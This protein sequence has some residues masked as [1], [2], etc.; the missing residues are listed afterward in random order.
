MPECPSC[1]QPLT[2]GEDGCPACDETALLDLPLEDPVLGEYRLLHAIGEGACGQVYLA[3]QTTM[4]RRAALKLLHPELTR[5]PKMLAR[6]KREAGALSAISHPHIVTVY[7]FGVRDDGT[8]YLAME[9]LEGDPLRRVLRRDGPLPLDRALDLAEQIADGL[10]AA[11]DA[12]VLHRDLKPEN[13][14]VTRGGE[15]ADYVKVLDFGIAQLLSPGSDEDEA[16]TL[17]TTRGIVGT[18]YYISPEQARGLP[19]DGRSDVYALGVL[20]YEL[21]TGRYPYASLHESGKRDPMAVLLAH[22]NEAPTPLASPPAREPVPADVERLVLRALEKDR[23]QRL[24]SMRELRDR[25]RHCRAAHA[26]GGQ[27]GGDPAATAEAAALAVGRTPGRRALLVGTAALALA[28]LVT[29]AAL[30]RG[31]GSGHPVSEVPPPVPTEAPVPDWVN[32]PLERSG[33]RMEFRSEASGSEE[34]PALLARARRQLAADIYGA[35]GATRSD[36]LPDAG[37]SAGPRPCGDLWSRLATDAGGAGRLSAQLHEESDVEGAARA[38]THVSLSGELWRELVARYSRVVD[39]GVGGLRATRPL[40]TWADAGALVAG[41]PTKGRA[42]RAGLR[43]GDVVVRAGE[44]AVDGPD[45]L[46][47]SLRSVGRGRTELAVLR[48][49]VAEPIP[50]SLPSATKRRPRRTPKAYDDDLY[51]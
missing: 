37:G 20:L 40:P 32:T 2:A 48:V 28:A 22:V 17:L 35:I 26:E 27:A 34:G 31:E 43:L 41:V 11:H 38:V 49:G 47:A 36:S 33:S 5:D 8:H 29:V 15:R 25:L 1:G 45:E 16:P 10:A 46:A 50:L 44:Q 13:G 6:F 42:G 23:E 30:W 14:V 3:E 21:L 51:R 7:S 18:P 24:G 9:Y 39:A 12:H 4:G 19:L